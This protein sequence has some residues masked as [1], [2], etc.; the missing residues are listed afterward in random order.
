VSFI[1]SSGVKSNGLADRALALTPNIA[2]SGQLGSQSWPGAAVDAA[3]V[4]GEVPLN[5]VVNTNGSQ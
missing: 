1:H 5:A 3:E 2:R 4:E